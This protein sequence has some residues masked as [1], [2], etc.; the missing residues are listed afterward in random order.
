MFT[1]LQQHDIKTI[2]WSG[3]IKRSVSIKKDIVEQDPTEKGLRKILNFGHTIGHA[4]ESYY[5]NRGLP[6]KHGE[7]V[8]IGMITETFLSVQKKY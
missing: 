8:A 5:L 7:A 4:I 6:L 1:E 2:N 3:W